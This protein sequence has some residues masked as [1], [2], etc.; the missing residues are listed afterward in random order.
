VWD[1]DLE[2]TKESFLACATQS[3]VATDR[4]D[5]KGGSGVSKDRFKGDDSVGKMGYGPVIEEEPVANDSSE[6]SDARVEAISDVVDKTDPEVGSGGVTRS[7][8][9]ADTSISTAHEVT[10]E[11]HTLSDQENK[12]ESIL[13]DWEDYSDDFV[14]ESLLSD[15]D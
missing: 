1:G 11:D 14:S 8:S 10:H 9:Q 7:T 5:V 3:E 15:S 2:Q 13:T 12:S 6:N 4:T